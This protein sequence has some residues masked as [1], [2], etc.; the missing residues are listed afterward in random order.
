MNSKINKNPIKTLNLLAWRKGSVFNF[1]I[2]RSHGLILY[3]MSAV[4]TIKIKI[5]SFLVKSKE[6]KDP[7]ASVFFSEVE[8]PCSCHQTDCLVM[9]TRASLRKKAQD[10]S[11]PFSSQPP[12]PP[13]TSAM[14]TIK[15]NS[16]KGKPQID[17]LDLSVRSK[18]GNID[19]HQIANIPTVPVTAPSALS[20]KI[21]LAFDLTDSS[22]LQ[23][24][25]STPISSHSVSSQQIIPLSNKSDALSTSK[26]LSKINV[27]TTAHNEEP[28]NSSKG[29]PSKHVR[30]KKS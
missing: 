1:N 18:K 21:P 15:P 17:P 26:G 2:L 25:D 20:S 29:E 13:T 23:K 10:F 7:I 24:S 8:P 11:N 22:L 6:C 19:N 9:H 16:K 4:K 3:Q 14:P 30:A 27:K 12:D 5:P 28:S